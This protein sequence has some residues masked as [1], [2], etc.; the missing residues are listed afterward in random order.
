VFK[1]GIQKNDV[2][3]LVYIPG[4]GLEAS[5]NG[6]LLETISGL[7]FK[8]ALFGIWLCEKPSHKCPGLKSGMLGK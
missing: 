6:T 4:T 5:K 3:D 1:N 8:K 2:F 7:E